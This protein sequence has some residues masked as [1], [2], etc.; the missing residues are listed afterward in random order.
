YSVRPLSLSE[1]GEVL[2]IE[3]DDPCF[4]PESRLTDPRDILTIC[5]G[6]IPISLPADSSQDPNSIIVKQAH[7]SVK[8]C[9]I[10]G[11]T[12]LAGYPELAIDESLAHG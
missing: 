5:S 9:L 10:S 4:S 1:I 12:T 2:A 6:L 3:W 11:R 8:D 7:A